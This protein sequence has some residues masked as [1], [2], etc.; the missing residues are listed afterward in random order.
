[1]T[2]HGISKVFS[3]QNADQY[4]TI[5][6]FWDEMSDRYGLENLQGLGYNWAQNT[7]EYAIGLKDGVIENANCTVELPDA[8][9]ETA[10][11]K[12]EDLSQ[13]YSIIYEK[14]PLSYEI[15]T[16]DNDGSCEIKFIRR[17]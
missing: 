8:G 6:A 2:F 15:E 16:F 11:G 12:T 3:T 9:W 5:G 7:I 4:N 17:T 13:I 10:K 1:M 14:G